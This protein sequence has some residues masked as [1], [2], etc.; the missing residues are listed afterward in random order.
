MDLVS[1]VIPTLNRPKC[2]RRAVES[3]QNQIALEGVEIEI[4]VVDNSPHGNARAVI[5]SLPSSGPA[6][7]LLNEPRPGVANARNMGV[8]SARGRWVAFLDDDEEAEPSWIARLA[9]TARRTG[10]DAVFGPIEAKSDSGQAIGFFSPYF[11]RRIDRPDGADITDLSA[12]L[13][14]NNSMFDRLRCFEEAEPF[15]PSLNEIGGEDS[16]LLKRLAMSGRR[17]AFAAGARVVEWAPTRRLNWAYIRKRKFLS[18][19]IRVFVHHMV[20][21]AQWDRIL[22]WM[23]IGLAQFCFG[24]ASALLFWPFDRDRAARAAATACGG[25]GKVLWTPRFRPALYGAGLVS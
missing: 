25:L 23:A 24:C 12:Y 14:T 4:V 1:I 11:S 10:A 9:A 13:G 19:Q 20:R 16:L 7:R 21:P 18:G 2:L 5:A 6:V 22:L 15:D 3:A 17:F 8:A